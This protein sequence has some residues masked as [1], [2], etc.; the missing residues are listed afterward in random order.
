[1]NKINI[2][3]N[4][5]AIAL[6]IDTAQIQKILKDILKN[7]HRSETVFNFIFVDNKEISRL[8]RKYLK[9]NRITDVIAF[10]LRDKKGPPTDNIDGEIVISVEVAHRQSQLRKVSLNYELL[11][12][13]IHGLLHLIGYDDQTKTKYRVMEQKQLH[14]L[15]YY[16]LERR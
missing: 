9:R 5:K 16:L 6:K 8:N 1:M 12:Y 3:N 10:P 4:Q 13:C 11:L 7:E 14:Y 2:Y 15:S